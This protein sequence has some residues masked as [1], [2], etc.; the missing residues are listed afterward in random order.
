MQEFQRVVDYGVGGKD[1]R[2]L[3]RDLNILYKIFLDTIDI[4]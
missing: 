1:A 3:G 2:G 4:V